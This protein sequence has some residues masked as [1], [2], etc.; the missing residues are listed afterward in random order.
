MLAIFPISTLALWFFLPA[1]VVSLALFPLLLAAEGGG[2]A[3]GIVM[4]L[5]SIPIGMA[6]VV[7]F[8]WFVP[9][10]LICLKLMFGHHAA[11]DQKRLAVRQRLDQLIP[12]HQPGYE[13]RT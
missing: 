5:L 3:A 2:L 13:V 1:S 7:T 11:A 12:E 8:V 6:L 9:W 4:L 10:Y